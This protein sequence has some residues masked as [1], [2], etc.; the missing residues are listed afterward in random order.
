MGGDACTGAGEAEV[1]LCRRLDADV[2]QLRPQGGGEILP[3]L[4]D[5]RRELRPLGDDGQ[6]RKSVV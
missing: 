1:L 5:V 4:I 2:L 6:D 3:H